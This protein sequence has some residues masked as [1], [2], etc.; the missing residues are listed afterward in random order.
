[1][2]GRISAGCSRMPFGEGGGRQKQK[3]GV[4]LALHSFYVTFMELPGAGTV[5]PLFLVALLELLGPIFRLKNVCL[6]FTAPQ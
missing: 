6:H 1:M 2:Q 3:E 5:I 4:S